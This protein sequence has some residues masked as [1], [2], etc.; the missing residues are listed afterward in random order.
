MNTKSEPP[1]LAAR[2][3]CK[4]TRAVPIHFSHIAIIILAGL[5]LLGGKTMGQ[6]TLISNGVDPVTG[7]QTN[8]ILVE[9]VNL[10][11]PAGSLTT[12]IYLSITTNGFIAPATVN[13]ITFTTNQ[14]NSSYWL[15]GTASFA[16]SPNGWDPN[17]TQQPPPGWPG[18][19]TGA[20]PDAMTLYTNFVTWANWTGNLTIEL[21]NLTPGQSYEAQVIL[22]DN[23]NGYYN[24]AFSFST[25]TNA[26]ADAQEFYVYDGETNLTSITYAFTAGNH[27]VQIDFFADYSYYDFS[28]SSVFGYTLFQ[29]TKPILPVDTT[30]SP[31]NTVF[32]GTPVTFAVVAGG[33]PTLKCQWLRNG[34]ISDPTATNSVYNLSSPATTDSGMYQCVISNSFGSITSSV[35]T[36]TVNPAVPP[37]F[38]SYP[39]SATRPVHGQYT[40]TPGVAGSPP[41]RLQWKWNGNALPN[42]TN[43]TLS[44]TDVQMAQAGNYAL[45]ATNSFGYSN[46]P[47][48][49]LKVTPGMV[50]NPF[51][52]DEA[53]VPSFLNWAGGYTAAVTDP[54]STY[55]TCCSILYYETV[56]QDTGYQFAPNTLYEMIWS[57]GPNAGAQYYD[58]FI[59]DASGGT[60]SYTGWVQL[61][62]G[63]GDAGSVPASSSWGD[64]IT[65]VSTTEN[66]SVVGHD[67]GIG[68]WVGTGYT[69][70]YVTNVRLIP[71][72]PPT[73]SNG[74]FVGPGQFQFTINSAPGRLVNIYS[75]QDLINWTL[76]D[77]PG[78]FSG[79]D[80]YVDG[81]ATAA[82][83]YYKLQQE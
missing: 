20:D 77:S 5:T 22:G 69:T 18:Y 26:G 55:G 39:A 27:P 80:I 58:L 64:L 32:A 60:N 30:V 79:S 61:N 48:F 23:W 1:S 56:Y 44:L 75:S 11:P 28:I 71:N 2:S 67:I 16:S 25:S 14:V 4:F 52:G 50:L 7:W 19:Y 15:G 38:T 49:I 6:I 54:T 35:V 74:G 34:M 9:A 24:G 51:F 66:P 40:L 31:A 45:Y 13:G 57:I 46:T 47:P 70:C 36:L 21:N 12:N 10:G 72:P 83:Q 3:R 43:A 8:G 73:I 76:L 78:N 42:A 41:I 17:E 68:M 53:G 29:L 65:S 82:Y 63:Y 81:N 62:K 59:W 33:A 37:V